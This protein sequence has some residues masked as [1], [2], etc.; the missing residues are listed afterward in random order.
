MTA[1]RI[2]A[3]VLALLALGGLGYYLFQQPDEPVA[4]VEPVTEEQVETSEIEEA[5]VAGGQE[6]VEP[7]ETENAEATDAGEATENADSVAGNEAGAAE[8][9]EEAIEAETGSEDDTTTE[10]VAA[11]EEAAPEEEVAEQEEAASVLKSTATFDVVR[12]EPGGSTLIA[13]RAAPGTTLT[14]FADGQEM[15]TTTTDS[16]GGFVMFVDLGASETPRVLTLTETWLDGT[17]LE[18]DASLI[19]APVAPLPEIQVA[20]AAPEAVEAEEPTVALDDNQ[21]DAGVETEAVEETLAGSANEADEGG[22]ETEVIEAEAAPVEE[23]QEAEIESPT[24]LLADSEGVQ[25]LQP[26]GAAP[27][28]DN[29]SIDAITYDDQGEVALAGRATGESSV[30]VYLDNAPLLDAEVGDGGQWRVDLPDVDTGTYTLRVDEL[31][32]EGTVISRTETPFKREAVAAIAALD[33]REEAE[34]APVSL[35]TV[36]PGNTLWGIA[37]DKYGE[38]LLYVRVFEANSDRIRNPDLIYP[39]QIFTV[40]D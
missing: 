15:A 19:L 12:V 11:P 29:V 33:S 18:A 34:I 4:A 13:G 38:G 39:G 9:V 37:R 14:L 1:T 23:E 35:L 32:E 20:E 40:P 22:T 3:I 5:D 8:P 36:Q 25:V 24:V 31:D 16:S 26:G 7:E 6:T 27:D 2:A 21:G 28:V 30:R 17:V 10:T